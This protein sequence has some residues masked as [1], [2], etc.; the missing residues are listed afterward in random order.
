MKDKVFIPLCALVTALGITCVAARAVTIVTV[1]VGNAGNVADVAH[2]NPRYPGGFGSVSYMFLMGK[3]EVTNA[4]YTEFLNAVATSDP[5]ALYTATM[6][7]DT[8]GGIVRQGTAGSYTYSVKPPATGQG[9]GGTDYTYANKPLIF[10]TWFDMLRFTNWLHNGQGSGDTETGAYTLLGGTPTPSNAD[11]ITRN[12]DA[13]WWLPSESEWYKAAYYNPATATYYF[14]PTSSNS[15]PV[16]NQPSADDGNSANIR[17][18]ANYATGKSNYPG[19]DVGQYPLTKSPYGVLDM[20][21]N[22]DEWT[23]GIYEDGIRRVWRGGSWSGSAVNL[24]ATT[25]GASLPDS[26]VLSTL[27]FRVA[28]A[29]PEP[30]SAGLILIGAMVLISRRRLP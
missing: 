22:V 20:A 3:T 6:G 1:P 23:E 12:S 29:V 13:K 4:Q 19:I 16:N 25:Y 17:I 21:G 27:G 26:A 5:Y 15:G 18:D 30:G 2:A 10:A 8:R 11:T 9:P 28:G 14:N 24:R 7:T